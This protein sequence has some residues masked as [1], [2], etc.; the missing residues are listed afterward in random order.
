PHCFQSKP[1][2]RTNFNFN[3]ADGSH[4]GDALKFQPPA[5]YDD[6]QTGVGVEFE[7]EVL[8]L[9]SPQQTHNTRLGMKPACL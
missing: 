6:Q 8:P 9:A 1:G 7:D 4:P 5:E 2:K 3:I